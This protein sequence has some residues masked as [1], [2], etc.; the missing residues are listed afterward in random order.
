MYLESLKISNYRKFGSNNNIISFVGG[1]NLN[2]EN[3]Q[4]ISN[5]ALSSTLIIG[6]NNTGKTTITNAL[7]Q[8]VNKTSKDIKSSDFNMGYLRKLLTHYSKS[9]ENNNDTTRLCPRLDFEL[10]VG[11]KDKSKVHL[12][13]IAPF[14]SLNNSELQ[15]SISINISYQLEEEEEFLASIK[16]KIFKENFTLDLQ[17]QL[18]LLCKIIDESAFKIIFK[19][20]G[21]QL[22][23]NFSLNN[24]FSVKIIEANRHLNKTVLS[25]LYHKIVKSGFDDSLNM[26][27]NTIAEMNATITAHQD[28]CNKKSVLQGVLNA[29]E[30][31]EHVGMDLQGG[32][33]SDKLFSSLIK[34][35]FMEGSDYIPE[36]QFGLGYINLLNIIGNVTHYMDSYE[37]GSHLYR[38]NLLFI[39]EPEVFMHPQMQEFFIMR[40][41]KALKKILET[42]KNSELHCQLIITTHSSHIVNSKIHSSQSF[43]SINYISGIENT[44]TIVN[45][46]DSDLLGSGIDK[47]QLKFLKTH[48]KYKVSELFFADAVIFVEGMTEAILLPY[49]LECKLD[50][51]NYHISIFNIDGAHSQVYLPLIKKLMIPCLIITDLDIKRANWEKNKAESA[52]ESRKKIN[53]KK[54]NLTYAQIDSLDERTTTNKTLDKLYS[55]DNLPYTTYFEENNVFAIFQKDLIENYY[56]SSLEEAIILG[57][58]NNDLLQGSLKAVMPE[59]YDEII[60]HEQDFEMLKKNSFKLQC[61][62]GSGSRKSQFA[63]TLL[64]KLITV[65]N[66]GFTPPR[67]IQDGF[68]WLSKTLSEKKIS[69][70]INE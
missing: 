59:I 25:D 43:D 35:V 15:N 63:S 38:I 7:N 64:Y 29:L 19:N 55:T 4:G 3:D 9:L 42:N 31:T 54:K 60:G 48:I 14:I 6:K 18:P 30:G 5:I 37:P 47:E 27:D 51:K 12:T 46:K 67:Y 56:A 22:I 50:L 61:K 33:T 36:D 49:F 32:I 2:S 66:H 16:N 62:L 17:N 23:A 53:G 40:I 10:T 34:Y 21:D 69:E 45:L 24:L 13:N 44:T 65:D 52:A 8:L 28:L 68:D 70:D 57:N 20:E 11:I 58:Y 1:N 41:D 26:F 39:E